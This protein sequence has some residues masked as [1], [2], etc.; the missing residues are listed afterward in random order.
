[1]AV[2]V[3]V[4]CCDI[5]P[6]RWPVF[7]PSPPSLFLHPPPHRVSYGGFIIHSYDRIIPYTPYWI[8]C[9]HRSSHSTLICH[10]HTHRSPLP[11]THSPAHIAGA[12]LTNKLYTGRTCS[13]NTVST[14][15]TPPPTAWAG[16]GTSPCTANNYYMV[17][18]EFS[19]LPHQ[20]DLCQGH[21][22]DPAR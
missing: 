19:L 4:C 11:Q 15:L 3:C 7:S 8:M 17:E 14:Y 9:G 1:M 16:A 20:P 18:S 21:R 5:S 6:S 12:T 13:D 2:C 10:K 22:P